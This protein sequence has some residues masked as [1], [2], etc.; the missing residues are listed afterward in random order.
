MIKKI[1]QQLAE[2]ESMI[3][4]ANLQNSAISHV[5]LGWHLAHNVLVINRVIGAVAQSDPTKYRPQASLNKWLFFLTK[6]IPRGKAKA[7]KGVEPTTEIDI[8][9]GLERASIG[10]LNLMSVERNQFFPHP[11]FGDL[12]RAK[13]IQFL[14]I[15]TE[16]H[17]KIARE[18]LKK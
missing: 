2:M 7:P 4:H 5:S 11:Y 12:N 10:L 14:W 3:P 9:E 16:H 13:T 6:R 1:A 18:I 8:H 17:L 15:H